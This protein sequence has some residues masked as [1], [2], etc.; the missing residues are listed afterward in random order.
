MPRATRIP[1][2][3]A[4]A[5]LPAEVSVKV[6]GRM[7][8]FPAIP[9]RIARL[10]DLAYNLWWT[11][12]PEAQTLFETIDPDLWQSSEHNAVRVLMESSP[13]R[14]AR[15]AK[16][17][18]FLARYEAVLAAFDTYMQASDTWFSQAFPAASAQTIA[19]FSAEF[20]LHE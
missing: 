17:K 1:P 3:S 19:Y 9:Q 13:E 16:D 11:W 10:Y 5:G 14:L 18:G 2:R 4:S 12:T 15:L 7:A 8:V 20:G 6:F